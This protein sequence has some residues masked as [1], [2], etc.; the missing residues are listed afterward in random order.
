MVPGAHIAL[1]V[2]FALCVWG[3]YSG[4]VWARSNCGVWRALVACE[5][6]GQNEGE[7]RG[8]DDHEW[9]SF[10]TSQ[11]GGLRCNSGVFL[12]LVFRC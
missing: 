5:V 1:G 10:C 9:C 12:S 2:F 6:H 11:D 8:D 4:V 3:G 7:N